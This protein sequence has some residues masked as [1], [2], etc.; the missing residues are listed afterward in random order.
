M[1]L[2]K[3]Q[4][5]GEMQCYNIGCRCELCNQANTDHCRESKRRHAKEWAEYKKS[6]YQYK[7]PGIP[8]KSPQPI[9]NTPSIEL[10]PGVPYD[11]LASN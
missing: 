9:E 3:K 4:I 8:Q 5:H 7:K 1:K 6:R 2:L 11:N 10:Q